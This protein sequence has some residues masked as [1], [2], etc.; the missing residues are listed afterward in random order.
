[1]R[2]ALVVVAIV[3]ALVVAA[4]VACRGSGRSRAAPFS[5]GPRLKR[6]AGFDLTITGPAPGSEAVGDARPIALHVTVRRTLRAGDP[7]VPEQVLE[8]RLEGR[9]AGGRLVELAPATLAQVDE[10]Q[11][12]PCSEHLV[13]RIEQAGDAAELPPVEIELRDAQSGVVAT[14]PEGAGWRA[15]AEGRDT[16]L[17]GPLG[18]TLTYRPH[19]IIVD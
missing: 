9:V 5:G 1:M 19:H 7:V 6:C 18:L 8:R 4:L 15:Q 2:I 10:A 12:H 14:L 16:V 13:V 11:G 3:A 17:T